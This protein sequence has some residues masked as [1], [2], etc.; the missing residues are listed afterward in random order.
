MIIHLCNLGNGI[1]FECN[2][3]LVIIG[4][5][6]IDSIRR[7]LNLGNKREFISQQ[8]EPGFFSDNYGNKIKFI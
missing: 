4:H 2:N 7:N 6:L 3:Q 5:H 1:E 8:Y